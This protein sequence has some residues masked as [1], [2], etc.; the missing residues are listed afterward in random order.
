MLQLKCALHFHTWIKGF[1]SVTLCWLSSTSQGS[2]LISVNGNMTVFCKYELATACQ[3][4]QLSCLSDKMHFSQNEPHC[5]ITIWACFT[6]NSLIILLNYYYYKV[7][8]LL[9]IFFWVI[10]VELVQFIKYVY[11]QIFLCKFMNRNLDIKTVRGA[12]LRCSTEG[13]TSPL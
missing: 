6:T 2:L 5:K 4:L 12:A 8:N 3:E 1:C 10:M 9:Y 7:C 11:E 13:A